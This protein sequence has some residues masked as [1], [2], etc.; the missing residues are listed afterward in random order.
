M[1]HYKLDPSRLVLE[2]P[3][4]RLND[5][6]LC[7]LCSNVA[8]KPKCC[9]ACLA[10]FCDNCIRETF[11]SKEA[12][13]CGDKTQIFEAPKLILKMLSKRQFYCSNKD[14]GCN[15]TIFY[16]NIIEHE[17]TCKFK[18][19]K[20]K[21]PECDV[22]LLE[23]KIKEHQN[24]CPYN[25]VP[26]KFCAVHVNMKDQAIHEDSCDWS[27][28]ICP[29]C[30]NEMK[31]IELQHHVDL[32]P[33]VKLRC[34]HCEIEF[35]RPEFEAHEPLECLQSL[36]KSYE[37]LSYSRIRELKAQIKTLLER[38]K[39]YDKYLG[40]QC[41]DCKA[42]AC[43]S[44]LSICLMCRKRFCDSC[45]KK[46]LDLCVECKAQICCGCLDFSAKHNR[47][48]AC[49]DKSK[50]FSSSSHVARRTDAFRVVDENKVLKKLGSK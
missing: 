35:C 41:F 7:A 11:A 29:G 6:L 32:C 18:L 36:I 16:E 25:K 17:K 28:K 8:Y 42:F 9:N 1:Q 38:T 10:T 43:E 46:T 30:Q 34:P 24:L 26:C 22:K 33:K 40:T 45:S 50:K 2:S 23:D 15:D 27:L 31:K 19:I 48:Y 5:C 44:Q 13:I 39:T 12:C 3:E 37:T 49:E 14:Y 4:E 47:C 21:N 20:C